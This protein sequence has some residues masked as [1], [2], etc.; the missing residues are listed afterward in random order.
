MRRAVTT[1][2]VRDIPRAHPAACHCPQI[3]SHGI[4]QTVRKKGFLPLRHW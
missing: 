1:N 4:V 2:P 3:Q